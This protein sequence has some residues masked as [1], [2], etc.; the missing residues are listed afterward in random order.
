MINIYS[1]EELLRFI[2]SNSRYAI[3]KHTG[4]RQ[5]TLSNY[6]NGSTQI[7]K[8][9]L[10]NAIKITNYAL[11]IQEENKMKEQISKLIEDLLNDDRENDN[12]YTEGSYDVYY[13]P[14]E[15]SVWIADRGMA[16]DGTD[17]HAYQV[18]IVDDGEL[19]IRL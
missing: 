7:T 13:E 6:V 4:I 14:N 18:A 17:R 8:M 5:T 9:S 3:E 2:T 15:N 16:Y 10:E 19:D 11:K 1:P 12:L